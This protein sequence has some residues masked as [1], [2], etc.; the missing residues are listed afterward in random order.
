MNRLSH[1]GRRRAGI[2]G[3]GAH[4]VS[5]CLLTT[6]NLITVTCAPRDS[7][8]VVGS[9]VNE[10]GDRELAWTFT[11][12]FTVGGD[13]SGPTSFY[14]LNRNRIAVDTLA[15]IYVLDV[16]NH[17]VVVLSSSGEVVRTF[18]EEGN[19]PGELAGPVALAV[20]PGGD[21]IVVDHTK[22]APV[23]F[24]PDGAVAPSDPWPAG[25]RPRAIAYA[26]QTIVAARSRYDGEGLAAVEHDVLSALDSAARDV[27]SHARSTAKMTRFAGCQTRISEDPVFSPRLV[28]APAGSNAL[29]SATADYRITLHSANG[30]TSSFGR[31]IP[32]REATAELA[33]RD[34]GRGVT[35]Q[36]PF[37]KC[38]I[39][40]EDVAEAR[41]FAPVIPAVRAMAVSPDGSVWVNRARV[42]GE[43][44]LIDIFSGSGSYLGTLPEGAP[45]PAAFLPNGDVLTI[46][47]DESDVDR[48]VAY[49]V[50]R[51]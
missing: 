9:V 13:E 5:V 7:E 27:A 19:G 20:E 38:E 4:C 6:M 49:Q 43:A 29:V 16:V 21:V 24:T 45:F 42:A 1:A 11:R 23:R 26:G 22:A 32:A 35:I 8:S 30:D 25:W 46:E 15:R 3:R 48:L 33:T 47:R 37:N 28:W 41:G 40:A 2:R 14:S 44:S 18:G 36:T 17:R 31:D 51:N 39:S 50:N 12:R 34:V 10:D